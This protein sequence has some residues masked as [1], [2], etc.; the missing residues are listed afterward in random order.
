M[1]VY[2]QDEKEL[3]DHVY[4]SPDQ[5]AEL[6]AA[7]MTVGSHS[8]NHPVMSSLAGPDQEAEINDS[9]DALDALVGDLDPRTF[10]Y[11]YGGAGTFT[12]KTEALLEEAGCRFSFSVESRDITADDLSN[13]SQALPRF[14]CNEFPHGKS[15][16]FQS[17]GTV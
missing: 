7:G 8:V 1:E 3:R 14:D 4:M 11:P 12:N 17:S 5:L 6:I 9:F 16:D 10:C 15:R 2:F 13:R